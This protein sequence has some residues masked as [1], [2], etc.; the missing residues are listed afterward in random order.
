LTKHVTLKHSLHRKIGGGWPGALTD[1]LQAE[2]NFSDSDWRGIRRYDLE[3]VVDLEKTISIDHLSASFLQNIDRRIFLPEW[4][5]FSVST[6]GQR[7]EE[8]VKLNQNIPQKQTG[9]FI[10]EFSYNGQSKHAR[11]VRIR[12]KNLKTC[13]DWH[14]GAGESAWLYV[15]ELI[16]N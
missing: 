1:G 10:Y 12:A 9:E 14:R 8:L 3:A 13:P 15:D 5:E 2:A 7:Y 16:I 4:V 11:Y 6:S